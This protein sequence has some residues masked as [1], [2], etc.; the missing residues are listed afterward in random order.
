MLMY[1]IY[2]EETSEKLLNT[3]H[4]IHDT[5]SSHERLPVTTKLADN[6]ISICTFLRPT[7]SFHKFSFIF[8]DYT[9]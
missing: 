4:N 6:Q 7:P 1:S 2:T 9:G 3:V 5:T 8:E